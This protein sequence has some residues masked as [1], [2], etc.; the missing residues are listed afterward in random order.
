MKT[1]KVKPWLVA[2]TTLMSVAGCVTGIFLRRCFLERMR[3]ED[4]RFFERAL[5][6]FE[7]E[8]GLIVA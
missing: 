5:N 1:R 7:D 6:T 3:L 8:G 2:L 4:S